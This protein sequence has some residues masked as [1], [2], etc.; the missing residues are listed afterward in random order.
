MR[1]VVAAVGATLG[2]ILISPV[3]V[4]AIPFILTACATR[5]LC[6]AFL[7]RRRSVP[8]S[9]LVAYEP[10]VGWK[11]RPGLDTYG[12]AEGVFHLTTDADGW[13]GQVSLADSD[14]VVFGDSFAF[15]HGAD[16]RAMYT[17]FC[18]GLRV[19]P[20]GC[21]GYSMVHSLL[22]MQR[23]APELAG[24]SVVWFVYCGNDLY[25]NLQPN[26]GHYRMP[27]V[28]REAATGRWEVAT[29]HVSSERWPF[30]SPR[31]YRERLAEIC[32]PTTFLSQRVFSAC[33]YLISEAR[34]VC[35]SAGAEL[36]VV[37]I[38]MSLQL[39]RE[40]VAKLT[41]LAPDRERFD[42]NLPDERLA[43]LCAR[44]GVPF[45]ALRDHLDRQHYL[46]RDIHWTKAGHRRVGSV[47]A[48]LHAGARTSR[49]AS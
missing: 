3:V 48:Q 31:S 14:I 6:A 17:R 47:L 16:D 46:D 32:C 30:R 10:V 15:G 8:W 23:L 43:A 18:S 1:V 13:R 22:W 26:L 36:A 34:D 20:I 35:L 25:E 40:G 38:P 33:D 9:D 39:S 4:L 42:V 7:F 19:K 2:M 29:S 45:V 49:L 44:L 28:R 5:L 12:Q 41:E 24:K 27:F 37:S 11:P 21:D